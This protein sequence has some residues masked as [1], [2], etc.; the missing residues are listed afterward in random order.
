MNELQYWKT[1]EYLTLNEIIS[2]IMGEI[3]GTSKK[4][5][6]DSMYIYKMLEADI[7]AFKLPVYFF[8]MWVAPGMFSSINTPQVATEDTMHFFV[9]SMDEYH[10][11]AWWLA[12]KLSAN[13]I[14]RWLKTKGIE[15]SFFKTSDK[16]PPKKDVIK[17]K[18]QYLHKIIA[19][20]LD[21]TVKQKGKS[22]NIIPVSKY[23]FVS[24]TELIARISAE[25]VYGTSKS[26]LQ[27]IFANAKKAFNNNHMIDIT[28]GAERNVY[29]LL[30]AFL[31]ILVK[32][33]QN[34]FDFYDIEQPTFNNRAELI[35]HLLKYN[36]NGIDEAILQ[37]Q[38]DKAI[39]V[40]NS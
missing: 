13:D 9:H 40:L 22:K 8:E 34:F 36:L 11:G 20:L 6:K 21:T 4:L 10:C 12:G 29:K 19:A 15:N 26:N 23:S 28:A 25:K 33:N 5:N 39:M 17:H 18:D 32:E 16:Q 38:F 30:G 1:L 14:G 37:E 24:E 3:P 31:F 27:I 35:N 7:K 2:L